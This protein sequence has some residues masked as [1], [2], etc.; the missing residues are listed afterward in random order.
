[1]AFYHGAGVEQNYEKAFKFFQ[2]A[3]DQG[4]VEG[5]LMLGIMYYNGEGV[6]RDYKPAIKW[7]Q[8]ASQ[9]GHALGYY[10]LG[11]MH[12]T[13]T[14]VLRSCTTATELFKNVAERGKWTNM[15]IEAYN[16]YRHGNI[17]QAFMIY[18]YLAELGYEV[19][20][21]NVAYL[22]DQMAT[23]LT[24]IYATKSEQFRR[25]LIYWNR[26]AVQGFH[27]ARVK[28]GD[29]FYYGY[30]TEQNYETAANHYKS[31]SEQSQNAQA[32]FNL[33]Y[34][35]E[36]GLGLKRD[37]H[38]AKRFYD[39]AAETSTDAYLPV[40]IILFKLHLEILLEKFS[41]LFSSTTTTTTKTED[42]PSSTS[43]DDDDGSTWDLYLMIALLGL[44][45]IL[46]TMRRQRQ[47][48]PVQ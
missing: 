19:A 15:F 18:L 23:Q 1:M 36:K 21:S 32:M 20:Q 22:L 16:L 2:L 26:A 39:L 7:L 31:A 8:A 27:T 3:A 11:Q 45:A 29:Y 10:N 34:M 4:Y 33:A 44:I 9:S 48:V 25:A 38:L 28:L 42:T 35:H 37:I 46:Y 5:Q 17:E 6:K 40:T 30:G 41:S 24:N 47:R 14:G 12:A 43:L 13:G